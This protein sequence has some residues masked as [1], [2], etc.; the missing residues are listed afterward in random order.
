VTDGL[1]VRLVDVPR[2]LEA[3]TYE[4]EV[5]VVLGVQDEFC[6]WNAG[7]WRL[8]AGPSGASCEPTDR[9]PDL[10]LD[11]RE[12]GGVYLGGPSLARLGAAGL[13]EELTQGALATTS[14]AF[15]TARLPWLDTGF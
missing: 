5:D 10:V 14:A 15:T 6:P 7:T 9:Q 3:R 2:A 13:V 4:R 12:L 8:S 11:V 1:W